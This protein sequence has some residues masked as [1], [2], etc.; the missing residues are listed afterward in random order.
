MAWGLRSS[1]SGRSVT[2]TGSDGVRRCPRR[3][4]Q[5]GLGTD[6]RLPQGRRK[7]RDWA[8]IPKTNRVI[9]ENDVS[10]QVAGEQFNDE[11]MGH[12]RGGFLLGRLGRRIERRSPC[13]HG[14]R[15]SERFWS[16]IRRTAHSQTVATRHPAERRA[17][18]LRASRMTFSSN[19]RDQNLGFVAGTVA[20]GHP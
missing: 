18:R 8:R 14:P 3:K 2:H 16:G 17:T 5:S 15:I 4:R 10:C 7:I 13:S 20:A 9:Q 1:E 6:R 11:A 19:F 12:R